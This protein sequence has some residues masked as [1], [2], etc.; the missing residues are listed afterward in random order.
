MVSLFTHNPNLII[1]ELQVGALIIKVK[2]AH[3][4]ILNIQIDLNFYGKNG[5]AAKIKV[6]AMPTAP[7]RPPYVKATTSAHFNPYPSDFNLG[8]N[9]PME[10][11]R[12]QVMQQ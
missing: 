2:N 7:L 4:A 8:M 5:L 12:A 11:N 10:Q 6:K 1:T 9:T 3:P